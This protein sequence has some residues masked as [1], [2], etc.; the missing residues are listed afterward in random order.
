MACLYGHK[1]IVTLLLQDPRLQC[2]NTPNEYALT[3]LMDASYWNR[4]EISKLLLADPRI[5][6]SI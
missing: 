5:D 2:I 1:E 3:P 4:V 6:I